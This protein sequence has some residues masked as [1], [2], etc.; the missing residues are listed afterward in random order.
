[1]PRVTFERQLAAINQGF[2][3]SQSLKVAKSQSRKVAKENRR[4]A[5]LL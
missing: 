3:K 5:G 2:E 1:M 4:G